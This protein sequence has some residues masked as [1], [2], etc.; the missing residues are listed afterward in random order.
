M[1]YI[2]WII[3]VSSLYNVNGGKKYIVQT[4]GDNDGVRQTWK[5]NSPFNNQN[6]SADFTYEIR[7][8]EGS[9]N[10][11]KYNTSI[12]K[13]FLLLEGGILLL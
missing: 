1:M 4:V 3:C 5:K 2:Y 9:I 6:S 11:Y 8:T 13:E 10:I 12:Q 7:Y